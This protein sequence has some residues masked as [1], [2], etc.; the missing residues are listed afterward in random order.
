MYAN[1]LN[2][3]DEMD[4]ETQSTEIDSRSRTSE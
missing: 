3:L 1:M 2:N 4:R